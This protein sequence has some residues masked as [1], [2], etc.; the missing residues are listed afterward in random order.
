MEG[1]KSPRGRRCSRITGRGGGRGGGWWVW[2]GGSGGIGM[3]SAG[4]PHAAG[5]LPSAPARLRGRG[6]RG[7]W[8]GEAG[9]ALPNAV[10]LAVLP[11]YVRVLAWGRAYTP[12]GAFVNGTFFVHYGK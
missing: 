11:H 3:G 5:R 7:P 9:A 6:S 2:G 10:G 8:C 12:G 4:T 1:A